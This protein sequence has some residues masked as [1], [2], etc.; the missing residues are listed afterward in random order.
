MTGRLIAGASGY[1]YK[2]WQGSFYPEKIPAKE[3]LNYVK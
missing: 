3:M 1:S 2:E